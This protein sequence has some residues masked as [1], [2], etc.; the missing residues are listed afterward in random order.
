MAALYREH[1]SENLRLHGAGDGSV[2]AYCG[3]CREPLPHLP[4]PATLAAVR[5]AWEAHLA[6]VPR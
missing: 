1:R 4:R 5:D 2:M 6:E 3:D